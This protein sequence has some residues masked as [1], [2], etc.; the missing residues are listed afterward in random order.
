MSS[1]LTWLLGVL[2][3][4]P[5]ISN[6]EIKSKA[7]AAGV[8]VYPALIL[9]AKREAG[10]PIASRGRKATAVV[11]GGDAAEK[12]AKPKAAKGR[13]ASTLPVERVSTIEQVVEVMALSQKLGGLGVVQLALDALK[14]AG[15]A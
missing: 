9:K 15:V 10:V 11:S 14:K 1:G 13:V 8:K 7:T 2:K 12:V 4:N 5:G 3:E 6:S